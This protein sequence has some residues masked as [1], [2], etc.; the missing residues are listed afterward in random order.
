MLPG[1]V[2]NNYFVDL[3]VHIGRA[4][5][6]PVKITAAKSL[7]VENILEECILRKGIDVVGIVDASSPRV[8]S[9]LQ[10]LVKSGMLRE[11][12]GGGLRYKESVTL[13]L[14]GEVETTDMVCRDAG[15]IRAASCHCLCYFPYLANI[16]EFT[17][18]ISQ[19]GRIKNPSLS[20]QKA[21]MTMQEL[22]ETVDRLGGIMI[23]AHAFTPHKGV[24]GNCVKSCRE[25]LTAEAWKSIPAVELGL[26]SDSSYA[27]MI[28]ELSDKSFVSN[29]DAH[30]LPKI[31]REYNI[32]AM[33]EPT[34]KELVMAL[35]RKNGRLVTGNFGFDPRLGKYHRTYCEACN[36]T[37][38]QEPP[39]AVCTK[40]G[41]KVNG[42]TVVMGVLDRI[43]QI[44]DR[45]CPKHPEHRPSYTHQ[46]PLE[47]LPGFGKRTMAKILTHNTEMEVLHKMQ[48]Q[49]L[50]D[51]VGEKAA[52]LI[53][54][55]RVGKLRVSAGGGGHYGRVTGRKGDK[56]DE[57]CQE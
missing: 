38:T 17:R 27:D 41:V 8:Q 16:V 37:V 26:S 45:E 18:E 14:G 36:Y 1:G 54:L 49:E 3:H 50:V 22:W 31:G 47:N 56:G 15:Q 35:R 7:T 30:S 9:D 53:I 34:F 19:P 57:S 32:I 51:L 28:S 33:E 39:V 4:D 12:R 24:Y 43:Y 46:I 52:E 42:R 11:L 23:P 13:I 40:C 25:I 55:A 6:A 10:K 20:S 21:N 44:K 29:S 48:N 2:M 5:G